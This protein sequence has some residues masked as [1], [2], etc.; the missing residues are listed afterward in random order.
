MDDGSKQ[1]QRVDLPDRATPLYWPF[2]PHF[3]RVPYDTTFPL[4]VQLSQISLS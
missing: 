2:D 1:R 3:V 4:A